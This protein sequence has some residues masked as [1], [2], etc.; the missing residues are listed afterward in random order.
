MSAFSNPVRN[1]M[2]TPVQTIL[3]TRSLANA[4]TCL[5]ELGISALGVLDRDGALVGVISRTDLVRAG[6]MRPTG[7][8]RR[9][10]LSLPNASVREFMT[11]SVESI[12]PERPLQEAAQRM[13]SRH[14]HRL[15]VSDTA[16]RP[17]GVL[18]TLELM[19]S[20]V[21]ARLQRPLSDIMHIAVISVGARQ[22]VSYA[23]DRLTGTE[24]SGV[25]IAEDGWPVGVFTQ[26]DALAA[27]DAPPDD[28]VDEWMN[29]RIICLPMGISL[30]R[31]AE[32]AVATRARRI[33][34]VD[35]SSLRGIVTAMDFA[36]AVAG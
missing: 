35:A 27:R 34:A 6:R 4:S 7:D 17:I 31:A 10:L 33:V 23:T 26:A 24:R 19:R 22:P 30:A 29:S 11:P 1:Y 13:V 8:Q 9:H 18:S 15:F 2:T 14:V 21:D 12:S 36:G 16:R 5:D 3:D 28:R 25:V 20:V 32:Q